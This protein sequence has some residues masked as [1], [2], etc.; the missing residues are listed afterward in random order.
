MSDNGNR[1]QWNS[2]WG[3]ILAM[4]GN[5]IGLGNFLRFPVQAAE[6]GGG[7]YMIPYFVSLLVLGVP[8][9]W[10]EWGIGR[11]GG[12]LGHGTTP[13]M[14]DALWK[15]RAAK[16]VGILGIFLPLVVL[17]YYIYI[18]SWTLA[19]S[20]FSLFGSYPHPEAGAQALST[21]AY[22]AP[23]QKYLGD[24]IGQTTSGA[25]LSPTPLA[26]L[27]FIVTLGMGMWI[28]GKGVSKGIE[29]LNKIAIPLLFVMGMVLFVR[30]LSMSSPTNPDYTATTG[31]SFLWEP[32]LAGLLSAKTWLAAAGQV[33]FTLSLGMGAIVTYASYMKKDDDIALSGLTAA[34]LNEFAEVIFG[35]TIAL[36]SAV[37]FFGLDGARDI[38]HGGAFKLGFISMPA[39][40]THISYGQFF[41]F[42]WFMLLFF[43]GITS[44]V[45]LAQPAIAFLEDELGWS[46]KRSVTSLGA[47][48]FVSAHLPMLL[49]GALDEMDFWAGTFGLVVLALFEVIIF[50]WIF[51]SS[52]AWEEMQRGAQ[53]K[54]PK[55]FFYIMKY[56]TPVFIAA[57]LIAWTYEQ[58]PGVLAKEDGGI[59]ITRGFLALLL[60]VHLWLVRVA[61]KRRRG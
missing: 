24:Y 46:R 14:F 8:L 50:F 1:E 10:I 42:L 27:F 38:S 5:A 45:A 13:G 3:L 25:I 53:I 12:S 60:L 26:Y 58:L 15:N 34:S 6:N 61:W 19:F 9:M 39:I 37:I 51:G 4:A 56:V 33:F 35:S 48:F 32:D 31:L 11:Y 30:V 18:C 29:I 59:W 43:A 22:L 7:A 21:A 36:T 57:I 20:I 28:L 47:F 55:V 41:G 40:F 52:N 54:I 17:V 23:Y 49:S 16:Y 44:V 2:R